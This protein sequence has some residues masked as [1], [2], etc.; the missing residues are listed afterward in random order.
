[1]C[2]YRKNRSFLKATSLL[3]VVLFLVSSPQ[4]YAASVV[5]GLPA[6]GTM[7]SL[8]KNYEPLAMTGLRVDAGDPFKFNFIFDTGED[9]FGAGDAGEAPV[10]KQQAQELL[11]YFFGVLAIPRKDLWVNLSPYENE[12]IIPQALGE[13]ALGRDLLAQDYLLK[14]LAASLTYPETDAGKRYWDEINN[15][16]TPY[17]GR[18][19]ANS[20]SAQNALARSSFTKVWIMPDKAEVYRHGNSVFITK[21]KLKVMTQ[22]DYLAAQQNF[23]SQT[24]NYKL[25][26]GKDNLQS[27]NNAF[28]TH[29]LPLIEE[30][31]NHGKNFAKLRQIYSAFVLASW[32]KQNLKQTILNQSYSDKGGVKGIDIEDKTI[33]EKI[34][35]QY[36]ESFQK[37]AYNIIKR[38]RVIN[39]ITKRAY[40]SGGFTVDEQFAV[41]E[42]GKQIDVPRPRGDGLDVEVQAKSSFADS[43]MSKAQGGKSVRPGRWPSWAQRLIVG[44]LAVVLSGLAGASSAKAQV[45]SVVP[46]GAPALNVVAP[47]EMPS[48]PDIEKK[49]TDSDVEQKWAQKV[50]S[51]GSLVTGRNTL[52]EKAY[53]MKGEL[54][55]WGS[56][57]ADYF[58]DL[59]A[60][61][62]SLPADTEKVVQQISGYD[63]GGQ[64][65]IAGWCM[66]QNDPAYKK[67]GAAILGQLAGKAGMQDLLTA[68]VKVAKEIASKAPRRYGMVSRSEFAGEAYGMSW[69]SFKKILLRNGL[70]KEAGNGELS[71]NGDIFASQAALE[72]FQK[73][74]NIDPA[75]KKD[76][77]KML[78]LYDLYRA[79]FDENRIDQFSQ[80]VDQPSAQLGVF[81]YNQKALDRQEQFTFW[82]W[83][84]LYRSNDILGGTLDFARLKVVV[85]DPAFAAATSKF[86]HANKLSWARKVITLVDQA[87]RTNDHAA[88]AGAVELI[89]TQD[90]GLS[91]RLVVGKGTQVGILSHPDMEDVGFQAE[92]EFEARGAARAPLYFKSDLVDTKSGAI[93]KS[94]FNPANNIWWLNTHGSEGGDYVWLN[95]RNDLQPIRRGQAIPEA[96]NPQEMFDALLARAN[97]LTG[98]Y[99]GRLDDTIIVVDACYAGD[100]A[101]NLEQLLLVAHQEGRIKTLPFVVG[102]TNRGSVGVGTELSSLSGGKTHYSFFFQAVLEVL[103]QGGAFD[104]SV[105]SQMERY[106][107]LVEDM[108]LFAPPASQ[109]VMDLAEKFG[110]FSGTPADSGDKADAAKKFLLIFSD[111]MGNKANAKVE[112]KGNGYVAKVTALAGE[113]GADLGELEFV[114]M[115]TASAQLSNVRDELN[116]S[117]LSANSDLLAFFNG[118]LEQGP[119]LFTYSQRIRDIFGLSSREYN[120]VALY[121]GMLDSKNLDSTG[122]AISLWH[123]LCHNAMHQ[124]R[125]GLRFRDSADGAV[126]DIYR[127][128]RD[129]HE[130]F[131]TIR[132]V[133]GYAQEF[134]RRSLDAGEYEDHYLLRALQ[135]QVFGEADARLTESI[136]A[137]QSQDTGAAATGGVDLRNEFEIAVA[138]D[139]GP[140][141][142]TTLN[143]ETVNSKMRNIEKLSPIILHI[144]QIENFEAMLA[145]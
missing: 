47:P 31:V 139:N 43:S 119:Q 45:L 115:G 28:K 56:Y 13:T 19:T 22:E 85:S 129:S 37:G 4:A 142:S 127:G 136:I 71:F 130:P 135:R 95:S 17:G 1:M 84:F 89:Q 53:Q 133:D 54:K 10:L 36:V 27:D 5:L 93:A 57:A 113:G 109:R 46:V 132:L 96:I 98:E 101:G 23:K 3:L 35:A 25:P 86:A 8:S 59:K 51:L 12:N 140:T 107:G 79:S 26:N 94:A 76:G 97:N 128:D 11:E 134:A 52:E 7:I 49:L 112:A 78:Y 137:M 60:A 24:L 2:L 131:A 74:F 70:A 34:Y 80:L 16:T 120:V 124:K 66:A 73:A 20:L 105:F 118:L 33:K 110:K 40:F 42:G 32:Y 77:I 50:A 138:G 88:I 29:I 87:R 83:M 100:F 67:L 103:K 91:S 117:D 111:A 39:K 48:K 38:K 145:R 30:E 81:A 61:G 82:E 18:S 72:K 90:N 6:P 41:A 63:I 125:L 144:K 116:K 55:A 64:A 99:A 108:V 121:Q 58:A 102:S 44:V 62:Y 75:D 104:F 21:A 126:L 9:K 15:S 114:P 106:T 69:S 123:E 143:N 92:R 141:G 122:R 65:I 14:Q 68:T